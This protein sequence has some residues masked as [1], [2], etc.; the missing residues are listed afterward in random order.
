M[1]EIG[2]FET[3]ILFSQSQILFLSIVYIYSTIL[4]IAG[5]DFS[6]VASDTRLSQGFSIHTRNCPKIYQLYV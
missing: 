5:D 6:I 1:L 3:L 2:L 4:G